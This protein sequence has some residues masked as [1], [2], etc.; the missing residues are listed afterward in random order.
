MSD[1]TGTAFTLTVFG[2][3]HGP[4]IGAVVTGLRPGT[5]IDEAFVARQMDK[6]RAKGKI[7][8]R[9]TGCA[10]YRACTRAGR[11]ARP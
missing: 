5:V 3:S 7:S 6:R 11:R 1:C 8:T 9:P 4:A 10:L 2:E